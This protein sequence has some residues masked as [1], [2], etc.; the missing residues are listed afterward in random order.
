[1][2]APLSISW[3]H[4]NSAFHQLALGKSVKTGAKMVPADGKLKKW[5]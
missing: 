3:N 5:F 4:A 2:P 1:L